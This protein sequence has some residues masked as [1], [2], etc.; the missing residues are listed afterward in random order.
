MKVCYQ[1]HLIYT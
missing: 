1:P